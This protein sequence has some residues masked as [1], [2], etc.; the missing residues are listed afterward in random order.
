MCFKIVCMY[1]RISEEEEQI[2]EEEQ[3]WID[4]V[5]VAAGRFERKREADLS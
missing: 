4:G 1:R 3:I 5:G 2:G